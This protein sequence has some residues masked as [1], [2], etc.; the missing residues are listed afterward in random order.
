MALDKTL[1]HK[2]WDINSKMGE[3][4]TTLRYYNVEIEIPIYTKEGKNL[5]F[6]EEPVFK[7]KLSTYNVFETRYVFRPGTLKVKI[8]GFNVDYNTLSN[9]SFEVDT[10]Y[11]D[12]YLTVSYDM[13]LETERLFPVE[14]PGAILKEELSNV[15]ITTLVEIR[16]AINQLEEY[17]SLPITLWTSGIYNERVGRSQELFIRS[18]PIIE[19]HITEIINAFNIVNRK[20]NVLSGRKYFYSLDIPDNISPLNKFSA[21]YLEELRKGINYLEEATGKMES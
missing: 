11:N 7:T 1:W 17:L 16:E 8:D 20:I 18:T 5:W 9:K 21:K 12:G 3:N 6:F 15:R 13:Y 4:Q 2:P 14:Y 10:S 19:L